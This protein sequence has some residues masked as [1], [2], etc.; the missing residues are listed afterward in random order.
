[1]WWRHLEVSSVSV[2]AISFDCS[3]RATTVATFDAYTAQLALVITCLTEDVRL[4]PTL[5]AICFATRPI[6]NPLGR[7][8]GDDVKA[9]EMAHL[10]INEKCHTMLLRITLGSPNLT[11][12]RLRA[13]LHLLFSEAAS[14]I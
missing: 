11:R 7:F 10:W 12:E 5:G 8:T 1:M 6:H 3:R 14:R 9:E 2:R 4:P 13:N